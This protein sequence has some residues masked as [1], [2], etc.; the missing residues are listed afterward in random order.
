MTSESGTIPFP[1]WQSHEVG[2]GI[3][4]HTFPD[5]VFRYFHRRATNCVGVGRGRPYSDS[6]R[7]QRCLFPGLPIERVPPIVACGQ[8]DKGCGMTRPDS[9]CDNIAH[10]ELPVVLMSNNE[11][12]TRGRCVRCISNGEGV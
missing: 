1:I 6:C 9:F 7:L 10:K 5:G 11:Y 2:L 12:I 3:G 8:V 4:D